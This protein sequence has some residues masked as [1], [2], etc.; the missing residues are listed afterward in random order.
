MMPSLLPDRATSVW[1]GLVIATLAG[2]LIGTDR[3]FGTGGADATAIAV[4][5]IAFTKA[6]FIAMDF[7]GLRQAPWQLRM[8]LHLWVLA[9][10]T[11]VIALTLL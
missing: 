2:W 10:G 4:V 6:R 5:V 11:A 7:M 9:F 3:P 1:L 8:L